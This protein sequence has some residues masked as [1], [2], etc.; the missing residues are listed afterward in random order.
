MAMVDGWSMVH[1]HQPSAMARSLFSNRHFSL[2]LDDAAVEDVDAAVGV[3]RVTRVVR[4]HADGGAGAMQLAEQIHHRLAAARIEV[5]GRLVR[6]QNQRLAG[7]GTR[8]GDALL[9]TA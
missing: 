4:H 5:S 3:P 9:L 7:H 2:F 1:S 8:D 6:E